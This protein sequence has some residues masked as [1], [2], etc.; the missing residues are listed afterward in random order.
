MAAGFALLVFALSA[1][2]AVASRTFMADYLMRQRQSEVRVEAALDRATI[3]DELAVPGAQAA[4][5]LQSLPPNGA[6]AS[7][8]I[9]A[10]R[11]YSTGGPPS[12]GQVPADLVTGARSGASTDDVAQV[13]VG[14]HSYVVVGLPLKH[15]GDAVFEFFSIDGLE[16][17]LHTLT[18]MFTGAAVF[19]ALIGLALGGF[20]TRVALRPLAA[21]NTA[22]AAVAEGRLNVRLPDTGDPDLGPLAASFNQTVGELE[23][24]VEADA[25]FA[26][27]VSHEL[28]TPV[29]TMLNSMQVI[30]R[31]RA[32]LPEQVGEAVDLLA[33]DLERFRVLVVDLLEI[34]R[35]D[36][37]DALV[38]DEV[39]LADL[40]RHAADQAAGRPV[41]VV[42]PTAGSVRTRVDKRRLERVVANLVSNAQSHGGGCVE[43]RLDCTEDVATIT[44]DDAGGGV[45]APE[46]QRIFERFARDSGQPGVGLGLAIVARHVAAHNGTI[47]VQDR[48]GGGARFVVSLPL[49]FSG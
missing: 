10:G 45:P 8:V 7:H 18:W 27:D 29:T 47:E 14:G 6:V 2:L 21:L 5:V 37:G 36:A 35:H 31:R 46:R 9:V 41:T 26:G 42:T 34:S 24:R 17:D 43:V 13:E 11:W 32:L 23:R 19:T 33:D 12:A 22:V 44:V 20:A 3:V 30:Q 28:R 15:P 39:R 16:A 25:R 48:P 38:L 4:E 1:I 49:R 40:V